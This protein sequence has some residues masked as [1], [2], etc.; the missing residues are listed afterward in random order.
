MNHDQTKF[1]KLYHLLLEYHERISKSPDHVKESKPTFYGQVMMHLGIG[2]RIVN[3]KIA[4]EEVSV[5]PETVLN[6]FKSKES[7]TYI[8]LVGL[9]SVQF[10]QNYEYTKLFS[11]MI[12]KMPGIGK[13]D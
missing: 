5:C 2:L 1:N 6:S 3:T 11:E 13:R 7:P 4:L 9:K 8:Q 12:L 10:V